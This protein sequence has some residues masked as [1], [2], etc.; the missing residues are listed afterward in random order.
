[1]VIC[2]SNRMLLQEVLLT[3][4]GQTTGVLK[5]ILTHSVGGGRVKFRDIL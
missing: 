2:C 4:S 3:L 5:T 1:M